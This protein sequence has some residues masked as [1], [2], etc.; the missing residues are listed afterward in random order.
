MLG[1]DVEIE[2]PEGGQNPD[3]HM[4]M[5]VPFHPRLAVLELDARAPG[6]HKARDP[7]PGEEVI[8]AL[9][10]TRRLFLRLII[11]LP[12]SERPEHCVPSNSRMRP[13]HQQ[14]ELTWV[15]RVGLYRKLGKLLAERLQSL[16]ALLEI[17]PTRGFFVFGVGRPLLNEPMNV[18]EVRL[19]A[20]KVLP[21]L[22]RAE[23][24]LVDVQGLI[25]ERC[26]YPEGKEPMRWRNFKKSPDGL[27][28]LYEELFSLRYSPT[29][30]TKVS[31]C[32]C[33]GRIRLSPGTQC[34]G[35]SERGS[36][37]IS[38]R[39]GASC[40][41]GLSSPPRLGVDLELCAPRVPWRPAAQ[42][43]P[44]GDERAH[45]SACVCRGFDRLLEARF[46]HPCQE[47]RQHGGKLLAPSMMP[48]CRH[49]VP[50]SST[51]EHGC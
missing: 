35:L 43:M 49:T 17:P 40:N 7:L 38:L 24:H 21:Y 23:L 47:V 27:K 10:G 36:R 28:A 11:L 32:W 22:N 44:D 42:G 50:Y 16:W 33:S 34:S 15:V 41:E 37:M 18:H 46:R 29:R 30:T 48:R 2:L 6:V 14:E 1:K 19:G 25:E 45:A 4:R 5:H 20:V 39:K 3:K 26:A 51:D 8:K 13:L 9:R 12:L 31:S